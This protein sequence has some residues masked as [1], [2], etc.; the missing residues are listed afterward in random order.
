MLATLIIVFREVLEAGLIIGIVMAATR[1]V[2]RRG[3]WLAAGIA[4]GVAG[5]CVVALFADTLAGLM[6]GTG[7]E[8]FDASVMGVAVVMLTGHNVWMAREGRHIAEEMKAL[9]ADVT[10]GR[11]SLVALTV[12]VGV[13][14]LREGS[15]LVLFLY[16]IVLSAGDSIASMLVGGAAGLTLGAGVS[17]LMYAGLLRVPSRYLFSVTSGLITLLAAGMA[18]QSVVFLQ[19]AGWV[20]ALSHVVWDSSALLSD[21]SIPGRALHTLVGYV[22]R[23]TAMQLLV[24]MLTLAAIFALMKLFGHAPRQKPVLAN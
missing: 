16:G 4:G 12:V 24:Y 20:T 15:E 9:G 18:A 23:P 2:S 19:Q 5:A 17:A 6:Y 10:S 22:A 3:L 1:G 13:A 14:V 7:Q 8:L 21:G 11:R